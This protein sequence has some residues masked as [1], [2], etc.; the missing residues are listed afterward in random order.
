MH[1]RIDRL[2]RRPAFLAVARLRLISGLM[3]G[4]LARLVAR[5]LTGL[6]P[7][8]CF[9]ACFS[10]PFAAPFAALRP[11]LLPAARIAV[12]RVLLRASGLARRRVAG[13]GGGL[14]ATGLSRV[15]V[16]IRRA[17]TAFAVFARSMRRAIRGFFRRSF[18]SLLLPLLT[19]LLLELLLQPGQ[20]FETHTVSCKN[21]A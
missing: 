12:P 3:P 10:A 4:V 14:T 8:T 5:V 1:D 16:L 15:A 13:L 19:R 6:L 20:L 17:A 21:D 18:R 11:P 2:L 7:A 9:S